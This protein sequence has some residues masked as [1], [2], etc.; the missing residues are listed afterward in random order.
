MRRD[1]TPGTTLNEFRDEYYRRLLAARNR[2][3]PGSDEA[4]VYVVLGPPDEI[5]ESRDDERVWHYRWIEN[6]GNDV[7]VPF[8]KAGGASR[9]AAMA[10]EW[11]AI[12]QP[13]APP[14]RALRLW[15]RFPGA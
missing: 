4:R 10:K 8:L 7:A 2:F 15:R 1:P 3:A 11:E 5:D 9:L 6:V 12:L 14:S 13:V